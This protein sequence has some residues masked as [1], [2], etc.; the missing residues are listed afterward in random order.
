MQVVTVFCHSKASSQH[1]D[2]DVYTYCDF[3]SQGWRPWKLLSLWSV[4]NVL[5]QRIKGLSRMFCWILEAELSCMHGCNAARQ[6]S[7]VHYHREVVGWTHCL[8]LSTPRSVVPTHCLLLSIPR[9]VVPVRLYH[10][11]YAFEMRTYHASPLLGGY[12]AQWQVR[13]YY[14]LCVLD[15]FAAL[16]VVGHCV[17][18][19]LLGTCF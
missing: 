2:I 3:L 10:A 16:A 8:L 14:Y 11:R 1:R 4:R 15:F 19:E 7:S 6:H 17:L 12:A 18:C 13:V 9:S 5:G